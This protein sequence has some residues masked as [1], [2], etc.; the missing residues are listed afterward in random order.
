VIRRHYTESEIAYIAARYAV[1]TTDVI[2][3]ELRRTQAAIFNVIRRHRIK[4]RAKD[5]SRIYSGWSR[6]KKVANG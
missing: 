1:T 2:A 3:K 4:R 6:Q 5:K